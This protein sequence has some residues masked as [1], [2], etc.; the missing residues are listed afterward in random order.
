MNMT[1]LKMLGGSCVY[2]LIIAFSASV[3]AADVYQ[4]DSGVA[5]EGW[6]VEGGRELPI[7]SFADIESA[8]ESPDDI[9]AEGI[10]EDSD[11]SVRYQ[12]SHSG[13]LSRQVFANVREVEQDNGLTRSVVTNIADGD[14]MEFLS[15]TTRG[16]RGGKHDKGGSG[17]LLTQLAYMEDQNTECPLCIY[18][19]GWIAAGLACAAT[20]TLAHYNCRIDCQFK[21]GIAKFDTG[22]C[23]SV[24]AE[25]ICWVQPDPIADY[26][27]GY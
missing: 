1:K 7:L 18:F 23:G 10:I 9:R 26:R 22:I 16:T 4:V 3:N 17:N 15:R 27:F 21:G 19:G 2:F 20:A 25:C 8:E 13:P 12:L 24:N 6:S 11:G 14:Q 5:I